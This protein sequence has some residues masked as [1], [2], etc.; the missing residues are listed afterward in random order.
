MRHALLLILSAVLLFAG[1]SAWLALYPSVPE[2]LGGVE[3]LDSK[4]LHVQIPVGEDEHLDG[5]YLAGSKP[6]T[7]VLFAGYARDHRRTW[8][9]G[10]FLN[11]LGFHIV[12][13]DFRSARRLRR[14]PTTLGYWELRDARATLDWVRQRPA[15]A[16]HPVALF[17]E[18]LGGVAALA[19]AVERRDVAAVVADCPFASGD[20]AIADGLRLVMHVPAF[21]FAPLARQVGRL[22]TGHDPGAF[23]ATQ[24]LRALNGRPVLVIQTRVED[25]LSLKQVE[26]ITRS[27]GLEGESWTLADVKHTEAWVSQPQ[28]YEKRVGTFLRSRLGLPEPAPASPAPRAKRAAGKVG[29]TV[30]KP[31]QKQDG[32]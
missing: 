23:D 2:D 31:L 10:H 16:G 25:R 5:W 3:N 29:R 18:S 13:V 8:R 4:S 19:L 14:K 30:T 28:A 20:E 17:G 6:A 21:P 1:G 9:Y 22:V 15:L 32:R 27:L 11:K 12:T 7:V 26:R 24:S